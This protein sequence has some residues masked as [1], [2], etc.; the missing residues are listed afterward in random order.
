GGQPLSVITCRIL[1]HLCT[2]PRKGCV[3]RYRCNKPPRLDIDLP[4]HHHPSPSSLKTL[5]AVQ[6]MYSCFANRCEALAAMT[7][8]EADT[9]STASPVVQLP[10]TLYKAVSQGDGLLVGYALSLK[11]LHA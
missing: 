9:L 10:V 3:S 11:R 2:F 6:G 4:Y 5:T 7:S 1:I 8:M